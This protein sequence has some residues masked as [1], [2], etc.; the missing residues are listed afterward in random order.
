MK[1]AMSTLLAFLSS[2]LAAQILWAG[3]PPATT[4]QAPAPAP[5]EAVVVYY[6]NTE[7]SIAFSARE[8]QKTL[9]AL[10][11]D[12]ATL[13]PLAELPRSP[14]PYY[15]VIAKHSSIPVLQLLRDR[16]GQG[17]GALGDQAYAL[18]ITRA[19]GKR[20]LWAIGGDR[21]GAMYGGIHLGE[22]IAA[23]GAITDL[24]DSDHA[25]YIAQRGIK[26]NIPLDKRQPSFDDNGTSGQE[27]FQ[28]VWDL[29]FWQDY[30]DTIAKQ[31]YN[32]L[33]LWNRHPFPT[34]VKVPGYEAVAHLEK[35]LTAWH[36]YAKEL[37]AHYT[38]KLFISGQKTFDWFDDSGPRSDIA[39]ARKG[40]P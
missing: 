26:F 15:V 18:R 22:I 33:S 30:L 24:A 35:A 25:P 21:I 14:E 20:G 36:D 39:I 16:G 6:D 3:T 23:G 17:T 27:N 10:G 7:P 4:G 1:T 19:Q 13:K 40:N 9:R 28:H 38:N 31:R 8:L 11:H 29:A 32:V 5:R 34:L 37:D 12:P 2:L